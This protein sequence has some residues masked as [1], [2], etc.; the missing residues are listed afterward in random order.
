MK[1][2]F[3]LFTLLVLLTIGCATTNNTKSDKSLKNKLNIKHSLLSQ[4]INANIKINVP[5]FKNSANA[6]I[7]VL[8]KDTITIDIYGPFGVKL[9]YLWSDSSEFI[10]L[11]YFQ[12]LAFKGTPSAENFRMSAMIDISFA[13]LIAMLRAEPIADIGDY[14]LSDNYNNKYIYA[15]KLQNNIE[16]ISVNENNLIE[17]YQRQNNDKET[18]VKVFLNKY[19][20]YGDYALPDEIIA[21]IP[22]QNGFITFEFKN[23]K[24]NTELSDMQ[25]PKIPSS[26]KISD[27]D[28]LN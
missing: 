26:F 25:K 7:K 21:E 28:A 13:D 20:N 24:I 3:S 10:F 16:F 27:L 4:E 1:K 8:N 5:D 12:S 15:R 11:N 19:S 18:L 14:E 23:R 17:Q 2:L 22:E 6:K 9:G